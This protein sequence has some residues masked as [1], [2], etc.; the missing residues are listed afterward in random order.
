LTVKEVSQAVNVKPDQ[1]RQRIIELRE[2][3]G[4]SQAK[5]AKRLNY[6]RS[7]LSQKESGDRRIYLEDLLNMAQ[8][9]N[10]HVSEFF[11]VSQ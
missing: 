2:Q 11:K 10:Q 4:L 3:A 6:S 9:Y 7:C 1:V 8:I 5:A